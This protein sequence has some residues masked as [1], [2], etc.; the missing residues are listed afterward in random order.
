MLMLRDAE[1][2]NS[3]EFLLNDFLFLSVAEIFSLWCTE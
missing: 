1:Y 2:L 3:R